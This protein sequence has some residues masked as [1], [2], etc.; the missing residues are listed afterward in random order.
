MSSVTAVVWLIFL[1]TDIKKF[2][3]TNRT[4]SL[5]HNKQILLSIIMICFLTSLIIMIN[6]SE[7]HLLL[8]FGT[9]VMCAS[10]SLNII[11]LKGKIKRNL[12][13]D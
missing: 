10:M 5:I 9:I 12:L 4:A 3:R 7:N 2:D 11:H 13:S 1:I 6:F 8:A